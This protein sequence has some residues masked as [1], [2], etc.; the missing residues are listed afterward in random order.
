ML[1]LREVW[2]TYGS[3]ESA[4]VALRDVNVRFDDGEFVAI[5]G[6][7]GSGKSTLLQIVGLL[8]R[9]TSGETRLDG[10]PL[11]D[12]S[13]A[14]RTRLRLLTLGF[15]FQRFHLLP[16]MS[17]IENVVLPMEAAGVPVGESYD[18]AAALLASVGLG[19]RLDFPPSKLSGGQRQ[20]VAIARA[21]GNSP[22]LILAD[23]PTGE[24]HRDDTATVIA[25]FR[26]IQRQGR[27][28]V[29]VTHD[30]EVAQTADRIVEIRDGRVHDSGR[31]EAGHDAV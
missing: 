26:D 5:V 24:L 8:D 23:E 10:A 20:R 6:P 29:V 22:R 25:L 16:G 3:G 12:L 14:E 17:A 11:D 19:H 2:R 1:E 18:R 7:S 28:V 21:L 9:P 30:P 31:R 27:T 4:V 15:V 13:D